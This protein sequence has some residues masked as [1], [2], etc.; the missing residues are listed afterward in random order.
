LADVSLRLAAPFS[1]AAGCGT[2]TLNLYRDAGGV[3]LAFGGGCSAAGLP[4]GYQLIAPQY[5]AVTIRSVIV[6]GWAANAAPPFTLRFSPP[7]GSGRPVDVV[8]PAGAAKGRTWSLPGGG[9]ALPAQALPGGGGSA[10]GAATGA[11]SS[12]AA[13]AGR[14]TLELVGSPPGV[15]A[16]APS[17]TWV[18]LR[19]I[20]AD[21]VRIRGE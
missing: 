4:T 7:P 14:Y 18:S 6:G 5:A 10:A 11:A 16:S 2:R 20:L 9:F 3:R 13:A 17:T 15:D 19:A 12:D 21:A 1:R 8:V